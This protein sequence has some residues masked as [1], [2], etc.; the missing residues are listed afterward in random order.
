MGHLFYFAYG[1]N[2]HPGRLRARVPSARAL[3]RGHLR[4]FCVR[5]HKRGR[6]LSAKCDAWRTRRRQDLVQGVV[7]R[8]ARDDRHLLDRAE[9]CGKGFDRVR[10]LVSLGG[11]SRAVFTYRARPELIAFGIQ[12]FDWYLDYLL[13]GGRQ[14]GLPGR[15]LLELSRE[16]V[17]RDPNA[18]RRLI[19]LRVLQGN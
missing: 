2:L 10:L 17:L 12:Q 1:S 15:Y 19:N 7:Y 16:Q 11:C 14:H 9:D 6:D 13:R 5:F 4:G 8:I 18:N 3:G